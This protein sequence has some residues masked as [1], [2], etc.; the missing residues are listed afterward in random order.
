M[1]IKRHLR[2]AVLALAVASLGVS[3]A[4]AQAAQAPQ[5]APPAHAPGSRSPMGTYGP[6]VS[7]TRF[8]TAPAEL[9]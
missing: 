7:I 2:A 1:I 9:E 3:F 5:G 6:Q 4:P 8:D